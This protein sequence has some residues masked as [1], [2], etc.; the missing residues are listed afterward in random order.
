M[1][2]KRISKFVALLLF[3]GLMVSNVPVYAQT[4]NPDFELSKSLL[5][6]LDRDTWNYQ[7]DFKPSQSGNCFIAL[8]VFNHGDDQAIIELIDMETG[9][10]IINS[11]QANTFQTTVNLQ[12]DHWYV[13]FLKFNRKSP[14]DQTTAILRVYPEN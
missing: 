5:I 11:V 1:K 10:H 7:F 8:D 3:V 4:T 2:T 6:T 9:K 13:G 14:Y 12:K